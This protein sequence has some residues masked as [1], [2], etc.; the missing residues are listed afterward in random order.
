MNEINFIKLLMDEE[1]D[2]EG[3][4]DD[5]KKNVDCYIELKTTMIF[6]LDEV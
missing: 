2:V 3:L 5:Q 6:D 1:I 4:P